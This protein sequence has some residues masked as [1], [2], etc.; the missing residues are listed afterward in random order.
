LYAA[1]DRENRADGMPKTPGPKKMR[2]CEQNK[3][4]YSIRALMTFIAAYAV[5]LTFLTGA[6]GPR[7]LDMVL[8]CLAALFGGL[9]GAI[10]LRGREQ[11]WC[12]V[13][14]KLCG[15]CLVLLIAFLVALEL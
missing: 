15:A 10:V 1:V 8:L 9:L 2:H 7:R 5:G 3:H 4:R 14:C 13:F 11:A 6:D 12:I